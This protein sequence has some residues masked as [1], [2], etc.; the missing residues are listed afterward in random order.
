MPHRQGKHAKSD[1]PGSNL[2]DPHEWVDRLLVEWARRGEL[3]DCM[4]KAFVAPILEDYLFPATRRERAEH[5]RAI[6]HECRAQLYDHEIK[7]IAA[8]QH[9]PI[10]EAELRVR[11]KL[12]WQSVEALQR[13]IRRGKT[14]RTKS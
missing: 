5:R 13:Y 3:P 4:Q 11:E 12:N 14:R 10:S 9:I 8:E 1:P 6:I 2:D 7:R